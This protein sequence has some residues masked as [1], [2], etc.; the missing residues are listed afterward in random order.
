MWLWQRT[1]AHTF[2]YGHRVADHQEFREEASFAIAAAGLAKQAGAEVLRYR[3]LFSNILAV[4]DALDSRASADT[5]SRYHAAVA[6]ALASRRSRAELHFAA[7]ISEAGELPW[8]QS[9]RETARE[10]K[11]HL[12]SAEAFRAHVASLVRDTRAA[13]KLSA[14]EN[15]LPLTLAKSAAT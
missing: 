11:A 3:Q 10:L 2:S 9:L 12:S 5:W 4:A 6:S 13:L 7:L 1:D 14:A 8:Q 15:P